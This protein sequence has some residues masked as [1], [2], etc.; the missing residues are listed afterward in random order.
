MSEGGGGG[1]VFTSPVKYHKLKQV[2]ESCGAELGLYREGWCTVA[3]VTVRV[4]TPVYDT[5]PGPVVPCLSETKRRSGRGDTSWASLG[6][7]KA[8]KCKF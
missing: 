6:Q 2:A 1:C 8:S 3:G 5:G 7:N 4:F